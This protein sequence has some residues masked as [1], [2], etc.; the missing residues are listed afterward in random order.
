MVTRA[1]HPGLYGLQ[2]FVVED[3]TLVSMMLEDMLAEFGC[4]IAGVS[5]SVSDA[6]SKVQATPNI[7]AAILDVN[8][9]GEM[10]FPVADLL[11]ERKVPFVFSTAYGRPELVRQYPGSKLLNKP[12]A[13]EALAG[14][15]AELADEAEG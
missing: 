8:I 1:S 9:G 13:P 6:L 5:A 3:E 15:L 4:I 2:V 10:I 11:V 14:V 7:D 12:Y